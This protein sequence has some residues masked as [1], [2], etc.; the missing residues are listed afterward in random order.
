[1]NTTTTY[2][3]NYAILKRIADQFREG[4]PED[5]DTLVESFKEARAAYKACRERLIAIKDEIEAEIR[6]VAPT[7]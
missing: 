7:N 4:G 5:I 1:M 6:T 2:S 3:E